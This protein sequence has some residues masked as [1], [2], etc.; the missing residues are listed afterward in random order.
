M[1]IKISGS[2]II[3]DSR[4]I[5]NAGVITATS[6]SGDGSGLTG[7]GVGGSDSINTTGI[8]TASTMSANE[9][10]GT[11]DK[12]IFKPSIT[13]FSPTDGATGVTVIGSPNIALTYDQLVIL[14]IGTITLRKNSASGSV[15]ESFE[16]G[17]STRVTTNNQTLTINPT[18]DFEYNQE[19][20]VVVPNN[21][22]TNSIGGNPGISL[23]TYNFTSEVGPTLSSSS[24]GI[25]ST[26]VQITDNIIL[27]FNKNIRAGVGTITL[28]TGS[29]SGT[30]TESYNV[31]SS[32]RL[33]F[34]ANTL[35]IDPSNSL[36]YGL[37]YYVVIPENSIDGYVG[38][39][40]Y[41]FTSRAVQLGDSYEGGSLICQSGGVRWIA[42]KSNTEVT[43]TFSNRSAAVTC[44]Q[45][46]TG[47]T[48][49][50]IPTSD[51]MS[52][53]G[54]VCRQY[55]DDN[56]GNYWVDSTNYQGYPCTIRI[57]D[58]AGTTGWQFSCEF[59][60]R[61]FRTVSY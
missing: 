50:F 17:V 45:Q 22:V 38:I 14:G 36:D 53:P 24:P 7:V 40:T 41:N 31:Q 42:A 47:C 28:R 15:V 5:V 6:F 18:N 12:L 16:V 8:I 32:N 57:S 11:A 37:L 48:G 55:W 61:A 1:A 13:S 3:D 10:I 27:S 9:F 21:T 33:T 35:T 44:A 19:Y 39:N 51:Q 20:Y 2:T 54:V 34:S 23:T 43:T 30:I 26:G 4:N 60:A 46:V 56:G 29:S 58:G 25:G 59:P 52:N 49:W